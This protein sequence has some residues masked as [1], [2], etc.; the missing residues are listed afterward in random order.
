MSLSPHCPSPTPTSLQ[1]HW[2]LEEPGVADGDRG[3][4]VIAK[5]TWPFSFPCPWVPLG[6]CPPSGAGN[7]YQHSQPAPQG[8]SPDLSCLRSPADLV[9]TPLSWLLAWW[10]VTRSS[11]GFRSSSVSSSPVS[12]LSHPASLGLT[13]PTHSLGK[14][15]V[16]AAT[17]HDF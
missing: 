13:F 7:T 6:C 17:S 1:S 12:F 10:W 14:A 16:G 8:V 9:C 15:G 5:E 2:D 11:Y 3:V 4:W